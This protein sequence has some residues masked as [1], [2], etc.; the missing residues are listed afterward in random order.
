MVQCVHTHMYGSCHS[1]YDM[2]AAVIFTSY[3]LC[4]AIMYAMQAKATNQKIN[5]VEAE[6]VGVVGRNY[7][8][9]SPVDLSVYECDG[10]TLDVARPDLVVLPASTQEVISVVR[11]AVK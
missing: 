4:F 2:A 5:Q 8:L 11:L 3:V 6:L 1:A 9:S 10:E 7:V